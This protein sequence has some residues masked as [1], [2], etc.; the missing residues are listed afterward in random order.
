MKLFA[1]LFL[2]ASLSFSP[3]VFP[4]YIHQDQ[5]NP[6]KSFQVTAGGS[7]VV[8]VEPGS[9]HIEPWSKNEVFVQAENIDDRSP[10]RLKMTQSGNTVTVRYRDR[11]WSSSDV[12]F[13]INVPVE[14]NAKITTSGGSVEERNTLKGS[15]D[16]DTRGGSVEFEEIVGTVDVRSGGGSIRGEKIDGTA[17]LK[18]GGG[19][20]TVKLSTG[21]TQVETGGGSIRIGKVGKGLK[22][23]TGGGSI[24][25]EEAGGEANV[26][27]GGGSVHIGKVASKLSV[28]T[29]GGSV[30]ALGASG[31][32]T[33]RTGG[34][35]VTLENFVG[36]V[37]LRTGGGEVSVELIPNGTGNSNIFTGGG[38][39]KLFLPE[40][41][42][43]VVEATLKIGHS[44]GRLRERYRIASDF[45]ADKLEKDDEDGSS[46][47]V[48]TLNGGGDKI[49]VETTNG[50]IDIR[51]LKK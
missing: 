11:R 15:F 29:G 35:S 3:I 39:V 24:N 17:T 9:V 21:E 14:F 16:V 42:K 23:D 20:V 40:N 4:G 30:E 8:D 7:L 1:G 19:N 28:S 48:Y 2:S 41:A 5:E 45:K 38:D 47:G 31:A 26:H 51:K 32:N 43:A 34:G 25:V 10:D 13:T 27:T 37:N 6:S 12:R 33:V 50:N 36:S 22:L 49:E 44:W 46:Y 18:T